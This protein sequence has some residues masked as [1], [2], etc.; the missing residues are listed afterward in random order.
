MNKPVLA[1][2]YI[3]RNNIRLNGEI[4]HVIKRSY[5]LDKTPCIT[6]DESGGSSTE[7][8]HIIN[9]KRHLPK[10]HPQYEDYL[11][12]K[13]PRQ[14]IRDKR[15]ATI[16]I[17]VWCDNEKQRETLCNKIM[18]LLYLAQSDHYL[19][20]KN[21]S[22]GYCDTLESNCLASEDD[23]TF[24]SV[25]NQCPKPEEYKYC[26][27]FTMFDLDRHTFNVESPY[28]LDDLST[29]TPT[30]RSI[31]SVNTSY[32]DYHIIGGAISENLTFDEEI[33]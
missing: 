19:F 21:Y 13:A 6:L 15:N 9:I 11:H 32:Y 16:R 28:P 33:L 24:R 22:E 12:K 7:S 10:N 5:P 23:T 14:A 29:N 30:L 2:L 25:K 17:N 26:N 20:C 1:L 3:L 31:I 8:K 18:H 4:V 27:V